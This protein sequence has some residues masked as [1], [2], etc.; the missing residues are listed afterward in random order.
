MSH[1]SH[2]GPRRLLGASVGVCSRFNN[3]AIRNIWLLHQ[4]VYQVPIRRQQQLGFPSQLWWTPFLRV[5]KRKYKDRY[6][7]ASVPESTESHSF[8][9]ARNSDSTY[10]HCERGF[11]GS[12]LC[13][14]GQ[15]RYSSDA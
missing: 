10:H 8:A 2:K 4:G 13:A 12:R 5:S 1:Q 6:S 15:H 3:L 14:D 9:M 11:L 7:K